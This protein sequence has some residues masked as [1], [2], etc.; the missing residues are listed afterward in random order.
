MQAAGAGPPL[1]V[2]PECNQESAARPRPG[3]GGLISGQRFAFKQHM[4]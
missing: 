2:T 4:K 3:A 1:S